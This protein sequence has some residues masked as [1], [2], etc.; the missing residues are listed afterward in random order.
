MYPN[1]IVQYSARIGAPSFFMHPEC[2]E[3]NPVDF[4]RIGTAAYKETMPVAGFGLNPEVDVVGWDKFPELHHCF[5]RCR[6]LL[7]AQPM[8]SSA[9]LPTLVTE[10]VLNPL[11]VSAA[12]QNGAEQRSHLSTPAHSDETIATSSP[13]ALQHKLTSEPVVD[14]LPQLCPQKRRGTEF[15]DIGRAMKCVSANLTNHAP[16]LAADLT[17]QRQDLV[18]CSEPRSATQGCTPSEHHHAGMEDC[19]CSCHCSFSPSDLE[20]QWA[21]PG[22][23]A[24][25]VGISVAIL[26]SLAVARVI[27]VL[28][29]PSG[30][31]VYNIAS[32]RKFISKHTLQP[33]NIEI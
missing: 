17:D 8:T 22:D 12:E 18:K 27:P 9:S 26:R 28:I 4:W 2:F 25:V 30:Q 19:L 15:S 3:S 31:R 16:G 1:V 11:A 23:A 20:L 10:S 21:T 33:I 5:N 14:I 32:I 13:E 29:R 6:E 24:K 7:S